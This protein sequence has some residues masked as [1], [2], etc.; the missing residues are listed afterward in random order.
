MLEGRQAEIHA[1][2]DQKLELAKERRARAAKAQ[3]FEPKSFS[4]SE[5]A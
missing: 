1:A 3:Q 4:S 5:A 2:R